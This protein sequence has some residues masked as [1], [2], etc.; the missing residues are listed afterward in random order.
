M[1][2]ALDSMPL[3]SLLEYKV[4]YDG[5]NYQKHSSTK[6][7]WVR[8]A[9]TIKDDS[10]HVEK[11]GVV[12]KFMLKEKGHPKIVMNR[13][14]ATCISQRYPCTNKKQRTWTKKKDIQTI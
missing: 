5:L 1:R 11:P 13:S 8:W 10:L 3:I 2:L 6:T 7:D 9:V 4:E 14:M 12:R